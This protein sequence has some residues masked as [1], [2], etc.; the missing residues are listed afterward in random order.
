M[1]LTNTDL[2]KV[3]RIVKSEIKD[4]LDNQDLSRVSELI[5]KNN[6]KLVIQL[7]GLFVTKQEAQYFA[8]K[9]DLGNIGKALDD[10]RKV[11]HELNDNVITEVRESQDILY[12]ML[13][14]VQDDIASLKENKEELPQF[15]QLVIEDRERIEKIEQKVFNRVT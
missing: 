8:T 13:L 6:K 12:T 4:A 11:M 10:M 7:L 15:Q 5:E 14:E 2:A 9:Q 3:N 1:V